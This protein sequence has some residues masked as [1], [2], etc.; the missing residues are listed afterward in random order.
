[1]AM[2]RLTPLII[3]LSLLGA[4]A[5]ALA[6]D[7]DSERGERQLAKIL[8]GRVPGKP[9]TCINLHDIRSS[10]VVDGTAIVY[11]VGGRLY[12]NR[13]DGGAESLRSD[14]ILVTE[15]STGQLCDIDIV[16]LVDQ[17]SRFERGFVSLGKFI[18][19]LRASANGS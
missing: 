15:S 8:A 7:K 18:P 17:G 13:P 14:D 12:V 2:T 11:E 19:Y 10:Q 1:M 9:V 16:R 6:A 3:G 5:P 4:T